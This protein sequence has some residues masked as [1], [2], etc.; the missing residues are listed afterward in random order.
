MSSNIYPLNSN[1]TQFQTEHNVINEYDEMTAKIHFVRYEIANKLLT[2]K[3]TAKIY[4]DYLY[5]HYLAIRS[6]VVFFATFK[7]QVQVLREPIFSPQEY[8][9]T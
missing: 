6:F 8:R 1:G 3:N 4:A 5:R 7:L 9:P 2:F